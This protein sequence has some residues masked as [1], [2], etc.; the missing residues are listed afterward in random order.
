MICR[1]GT[2]GMRCRRAAGSVLLVF[3]VAQSGCTYEQV[4]CGL[5]ALGG[6][7]LGASLN[8]SG[9]E[10]VYGGLGIAAVGYAIYAQGDKEFPAIPRAEMLA[11]APEGPE[12][13]IAPG[14]VSLVHR[15]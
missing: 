8:N 5:G 9:E 4:G 2:S 11:T 13:R 3:L 10:L 14:G 7:L 1:D 15:F 6:A 12:I